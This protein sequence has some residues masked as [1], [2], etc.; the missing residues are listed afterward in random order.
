LFPLIYGFDEDNVAI[1]S[2]KIK[3]VF[4]KKELVDSEKENI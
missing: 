2:F 3:S 4:D 1:D